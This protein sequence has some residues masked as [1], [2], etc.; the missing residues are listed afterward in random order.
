MPA[1]GWYEWNENEPVLSESGRKVNQ[2]Y[3]LYSPSAEVI[4]FAA[5]WSV[6]E[7]PG[8]EPVVSCALLSKDAAPS[9]SAIHHRMP[10]VLS[11]EQCEAW[12]SPTASAQDIAD[13]I[14]G[15][16]VDFEGYAASTKVNNARNDFPELLEKVRVHSNYSL[17]ARRP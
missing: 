7:R 16:R 15:A 13:L 9:I 8:V 11:P 6:W 4:A 2:P 10:V 3:F 17:Q 5:L 12:L 1:R 14:A